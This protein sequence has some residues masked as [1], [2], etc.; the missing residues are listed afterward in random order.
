[1]QKS[2][3]EYQNMRVINCFVSIS[4]KRVRNRLNP[5]DLQRACYAQA[6][7]SAEVIDKKEGLE[8]GT[9]KRKAAACCR[10]PRPTNS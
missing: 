8:K 3:Q 1:V 10:T 5:K 2:A 7:K 9:K 6:Q 4:C